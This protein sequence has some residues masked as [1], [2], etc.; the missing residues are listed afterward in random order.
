MNIFESL[1]NLNVSEECFDEIMKIVE[2]YIN[3]LKNETIEKTLDKRN[4]QYKDLRAS[5]K[6]KEAS[7]EGRK[8]YK[9][10]EI[11]KARARKKGLNLISTDKGEHVH[12]RLDGEKGGVTHYSRV[13]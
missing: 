10:F 1:E 6:D 9:A 5:G 4:D 13:K 12:T 3:E 8:Y 2:G 7:K 11:A